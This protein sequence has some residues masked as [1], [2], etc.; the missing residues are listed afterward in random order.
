M[1]ENKDF[2]VFK[3]LSV[4]LH[5][6]TCSSEQGQQELNKVRMRTEL[7]KK[8]KWDSSS[9][10]GTIV[11]EKKVMLSHQQPAPLKVCVV[12]VCRSTFLYVVKS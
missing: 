11:C 3:S 5:R 9:L 12:T 1:F 4:Y 8:K 10:L 7:K 6:Q 2:T